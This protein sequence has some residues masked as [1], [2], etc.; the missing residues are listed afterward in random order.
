MKQETGLVDCRVCKGAGMPFQF[1]LCSS[2]VC[3][4]DTTFYS[5]GHEL[6]NQTLGHKTWILLVW[7]FL[8]S[9]VDLTSPFVNFQSKNIRGLF[10]CI[11]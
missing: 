7:A 3:S 9:W 8:W 2:E 6:P 4:L 1:N 11:E 5:D 10:V